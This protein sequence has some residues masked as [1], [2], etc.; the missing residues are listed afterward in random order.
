MLLGG[1]GELLSTGYGR[2]LSVK[3]GLTLA[4]LALGARQ[5]HA[6]A[7][8]W[9]PAAGGVFAGTARI[10]MLLGIVVLATTALLAGEAA[11]A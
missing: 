5:R 1:P 7:R 9:Q 6:L 8:R 10:E 4:L 2:L 11:H 3:I